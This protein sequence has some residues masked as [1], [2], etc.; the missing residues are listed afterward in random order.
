MSFLQSNSKKN[1]WQLLPGNFNIIVCSP[2]YQLVNIFISR[3]K[4]FPPSLSLPSGSTSKLNHQLFTLIIFVPSKMIFACLVKS[5]R[6]FSRLFT[7]KKRKNSVN[8]KNEM[9]YKTRVHDYKSLCIPFFPSSLPCVKMKIIT[10]HGKPLKLTIKASVFIKTI[11]DCGSWTSDTWERVL[12]E[13]AFLQ[14]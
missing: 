11:V 12:F 9:G 7:L 4:E 8:Q 1:N 10:T 13:E 5:L 2:V 3:G 6:L 14:G